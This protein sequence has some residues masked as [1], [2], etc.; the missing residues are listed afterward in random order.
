M[1]RS[2]SCQ[3]AVTVE[4]GLGAPN[5]HCLWVEQDSLV[6]WHCADSEAALGH[7]FALQV[8]PRGHSDSLGC[9]L[10]FVLL[11]TG[12]FLQRS[13]SSRRIVARTAEV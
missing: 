9:R 8:D 11:H 1:R 12:S 3:H 13:R 6:S 4:D 10:D 7:C 2:G 5:W